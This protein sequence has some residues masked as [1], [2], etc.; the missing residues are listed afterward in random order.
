MRKCNIPYGRI[1]TCLKNKSHVIIDAL[2]RQ[3][4]SKKCIPDSLS[5][6]VNDY[7]GN[8][9]DSQIN[10]IETS[11]QG[12][13]TED[14]LS[15]LNNKKE[16]TVYDIPIIVYCAN[17]S[18]RKSEDL[19]DILLK[20]GFL[21]V[22][23]YPGGIKEWV[24]KGGATTKGGCAKGGAPTLA[25]IQQQTTNWLYGNKG[26]ND[27]EAEQKGNKD[28]PTSPKEDK[29]KV[30]KPPKQEPVKIIRKKQVS[31][32]FDLEGQFE[33]LVYEDIVYIHN[34]ENNKVFTTNDEEVGVLK[35]KNIKWKSD[36]YKKNHILAKNKFNEE[37]NK[38]LV[39]SSSEDED[40]S[41]DEESS[42]GEDLSDE[43]K[44]IKKDVDNIKHRKH[45]LSLKCMSDV[46]P[47]V[48]NE[49]FRGWGFT[50]WG[51]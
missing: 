12:S 1:Q 26:N 43:I 51:N 36:E 17:T 14:I 3:S 30:V 49:R 11:I 6:P 40:T 47:K 10:D 4:H 35:G 50:Y 48:Y 7:T 20:L 5:L 18:C 45:K 34:V 44:T 2:P 46:T 33:K 13:I 16:P 9:N 38:D 42:S 37:Y 27:E 29:K 25:K 32:E 19:V 28:K 31:N 22:S 24:L 39:I 23:N 21:N 41:S 8:L 15:Q